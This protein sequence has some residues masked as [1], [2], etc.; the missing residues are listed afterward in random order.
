MAYDRLVAFKLRREWLRE[1]DERLAA[2]I[3]A[4][5]RK[6]GFAGLGTMRLVLSG[7]SEMLHPA[8][9]RRGSAG[10]VAAVVPGQLRHAVSDTALTALAPMQSPAG[11]D[12]L[13]NV[14]S[15][16]KGAGAAHAEDVQIAVQQ[17]TAAPSASRSR[18]AAAF[19]A[20]PAAADSVAV[21][22]AVAGATTAPQAGQPEQ[23]PPPR[24]H[25]RQARSDE[26]PVSSP[27]LLVPAPGKSAGTGTLASPSVGIGSLGAA[28]G[29]LRPGSLTREDVVI[30]FIDATDAE[31]AFKLFDLDGDGIVSRDE[32]I[33]SFSLM[34][35]AWEATRTALQ[36]YG[37]ISDA[38]RMLTDTVLWI[39]LFLITLAI[40]GVNF[41]T[42]LVPLSTTII[43]LG[44]ALGPAI[45]RLIESLIFVLVTQP[46]DVGDRVAIDK[47]LA[48]GGLTVHA[49][50]VLSTDFTDSNGKRVTMRNSEL[51]SACITNLRRSPTTVLSA[52]FIVDHSVA[53]EELKSLKEHVE[54]YLRGNQLQWK[55][56]CSM[57]I[58][59]A[60]ANKVEVT[61]WVTSHASWQEGGK[62]WPAYSQLLLHIIEALRDRGL[63]YALPPQPIFGLAADGAPL[64]GL[65]RGTAGRHNGPGGRG[66]T[67]TRRS[68]APPPT[69]TD[70]KSAMVAGQQRSDATGAAA[71]SMSDDDA[72]NETGPLLGN[73]RVSDGQDAAA[74]PELAMTAA[75]SAPT[76]G[77]LRQRKKGS[78]EEATAAPFPHALAATTGSASTNS[79]VAPAHTAGPA[80]RE[81][82]PDPST[83][84]SFTRVPFA[85]AGQP[86]ARVSRMAALTLPTVV[87]SGSTPQGNAASGGMVHA[88]GSA[89]PHDAAAHGM[90][91]A[92]ATGTPPHSGVSRR[93]A[94]AASTHGSHNASSDAR[95]PAVQKQ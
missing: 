55:P 46:Y 67:R 59:H 12:G 77:T 75:A 44:F 37:G 72:D 30:C 1:R 70:G 23:D 48:G 13:D 93:G 81:G 79:A 88:H 54:S 68:T 43:G 31:A 83:M 3:D 5:R 87:E 41:S 51:A 64:G 10:L 34:F 85:G 11:S 36:S 89:A 47:V 22:A 25:V 32:F 50:N 95:P 66:F 18:L 38:I 76:G 74:S 28:G 92:A 69:R 24:V 61:F 53:A 33:S 6:H 19:R 21:A 82:P 40:Y 17:Q 2:H 35:N 29:K 94:A 4:A 42:A 20:Q 9:E 49:I 7:V 56:S 60:E 52:K 86:H 45:Q 27:R 16:A 90:G 26:G 58:G 65:L 39:V 71:A 57:M 62:V 63:E 84:S 14:D 73:T 78:G 91:E 8:T 15:V 80:L